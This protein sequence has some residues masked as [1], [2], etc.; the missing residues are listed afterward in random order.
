MRRHRARSFLSLTLP[1]L[2]SS[3]RQLLELRV[4]DQVRAAGAAREPGPDRGHRLLHRVHQPP[5][6]Q[7][8]QRELPQCLT[9][10]ED[11]YVPRFGIVRLK[12]VSGFDAF[13][14]LMHH[15]NNQ[16]N[17]RVR[18]PSRSSAG[19]LEV[20]RSVRGQLFGCFRRLRV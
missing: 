12:G 6:V 18:N 1:L 16:R 14:F 17:A 19:A 15:E 10:V 2:T 7:P 4:H 9:A 5:H 3:G 20:C 11:L 8:L 13:S